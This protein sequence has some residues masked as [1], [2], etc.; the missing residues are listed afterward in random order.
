MNE[1]TNQLRF[2]DGKLEQLVLVHPEP[3]ET[4]TAAEM[5]ESQETWIEVEGQS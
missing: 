3:N 5:P 2:T 1:I 4:Q